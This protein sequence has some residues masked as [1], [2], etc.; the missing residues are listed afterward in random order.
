[1][2]FHV[3]FPLITN[4]QVPSNKVSI[5]E[6]PSEFNTIVQ[7]ELEKGH[8]LGP[9]SEKIMLELIASGKMVFAI[10]VYRCT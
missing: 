8:F 3:D 7:K 1:M 10:F 9:F 4:V 2:G 6:F 5:S